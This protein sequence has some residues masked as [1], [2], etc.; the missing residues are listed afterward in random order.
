MT[1]FSLIKIFTGCTLAFAVNGCDIA[2]KA[3]DAK[4]FNRSTEAIVAKF[5][6]ENDRLSDLFE[7]SYAYAVFPTVG[8]GGLVLAHGF[9]NG[10][11][12]EGG[13][14][15]GYA[16]VS[17]HAIG[18]IVGGV[19]WSLLLFLQDK[20]AL[21]KFQSGSLQADATANYAAGES[22]GNSQTE[23]SNGFIAIKVDPAGLIGDASVGFSDFKY[24]SLSETEAKW[25]KK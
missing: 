8:M 23:Y 3:N 19:K 20:A 10:G 22:G 14:L 24:Q 1:R 25:D 15:I 18:A 6:S 13:E 21:G 11:V 5:S 12:Y 4:D 17:E 16:S 9:G 7:N 2:P